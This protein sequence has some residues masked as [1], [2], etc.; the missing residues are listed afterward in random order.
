MNR[1]QITRRNFLKGVAV[2]GLGAASAQL[3]SA[4]VPPSGAPGSAGGDAAP[5]A[6]AITLRIQVPAGNLALTPQEFGPRF[7]EET[8]VEVVVE[9]TIYGEIETK[10]QTGF[11]AGTLQDLLYGHHRWIFIN[12]VK[13]IYLETDDLWASSPPD[14]PDDFYPSVLEGNK[15]Q[16][17][18]FNLPDVVHPGGNIALAFNKTMLEEKGL[19]IPEVGWTIQDWSDL[20]REAADPDAGIFGMGFDSMSAMHYYSN[21]S[22]SFGDVD[23]TDSWIMDAEGRTMSYN[24]DLHAEIAAWYVSLLDDKVAPRAADKEGVEPN[25]FV[26]GLEATHASTVGVLTRAQ[27]QAGDR[28]EVGAIPLPP[29]QTG[30]QGTCFSGNHWMINSNSAAPD[31]AWEF[32]KL[33]TSKEAGIFNVLE[34]KRQTNGRKSVWTDP[35]VNAVNP[36]YGFTDT[37]IT[38]GVEPYPM[39]W[40]T[41][42]TEANNVFRSEID[43][44]WEGEETFEGYAA[45]IERKTQAILDEPMPS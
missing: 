5:A 15:W 12:F 20:A 13:G 28:F 21:T 19:A 32:A 16:G 44:I 11:I 6:E 42:F 9:E 37:V 27:A 1:K 23:S 38:E 18:S 29:G 2:T 36:L 40:N 10:T 39:P 8:G 4:C 7:T 35:E 3:L 45:E 24:T 33:L 17:K 22:R 25:L 34:A 30:R 43:L 14:D 26:A 31:E 41:R